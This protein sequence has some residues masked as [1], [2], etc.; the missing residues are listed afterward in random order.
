WKL[1]FTLLLLTGTV[2]GGF[3]Q[4]ATVNGVVTD[5]SQAIVA[6]A[7]VTIT[8]IETGLRRDT[9]TNDAGYYTFTL[10]PVGKYRFEAIMPGF[11]TQSLP[12]VQLD[13]DQVVRL[14]F[15]LKPGAL[16]ES[17]EVTASAALLDSDTATVGQVISNKSIVEMPLNGRNYLNLA[18]LT[19]GTAPDTGGR[20]QSEGGFVSGGAHSYQMN[21]QVDGLDNNTIY[22]G[23]PIGYEAQSANP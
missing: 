21:V 18:T 17:V 5:S 15:S 22:S 2:I 7:E 12:Q 8:N 9:R 13:V 19:A 16:T 20:T 14:D 1:C 11:S 10:L 23:G 4:T 3:G 6:G